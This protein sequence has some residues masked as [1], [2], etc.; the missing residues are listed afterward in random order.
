MDISSIIR[1]ILML[2]LIGALGVYGLRFA[3]KLTSKV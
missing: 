3:G 1:L 2:A